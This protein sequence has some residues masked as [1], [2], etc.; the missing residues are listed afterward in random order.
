MTKEEL[1]NLPIKINA[2][3]VK[4]AK[5]I[6]KQIEKLNRKDDLGRGGNFLRAM[7]VIHLV[8]EQQRLDLLR[9]DVALI[10][11]KLNLEEYIKTLESEDNDEQ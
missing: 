10:D 8:E 2:Q 11:M 3:V 4:L 6:N 5:K 7:R 9:S 1:N